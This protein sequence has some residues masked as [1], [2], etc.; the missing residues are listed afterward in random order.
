MHEVSRRQALA[1]AI[2]GVAGVGAA[3]AAPVGAT[4]NRKDSLVI[5]L[6]WL[7]Q[8]TRLLPMLPMN[9]LAPDVPGAFRGWA[10]YTEGVLLPAGTIPGTPEQPAFGFD[11]STAPRIGTYFGWGFVVEDFN[12]SGST[13]PTLLL[14]SQ[15]VFGTIDVEHYFPADQLV[16]SGL[17]F[18]H[19]DQTRPSGRH[20]HPVQPVTGGGGV[21]AGATGVVEKRYIGTNTSAPDDGA[22][23]PRNYRLEFTLSYP[24]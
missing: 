9:P 14:T 20:Q 10:V 4:P 17:E 24:D 13:D 11:P 18:A 1:A 6:A 22:H 16:S 23:A 19:T 21:Y 7:G 15:Y 12:R 2:V 3:R 5:D 8:T